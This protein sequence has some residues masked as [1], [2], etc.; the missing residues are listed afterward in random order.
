MA[1]GKEGVSPQFPHCC[2]P[3]VSYTQ[4]ILFTTIIHSVLG[5]YKRYFSF[6]LF[7]QC[8]TMV[9]V[10]YLCTP[11]MQYCDLCK[12]SGGDTTV[13]ERLI[14]S[15]VTITNRNPIRSEDLDLYSVI[16]TQ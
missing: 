6:R 10:C 7:Q 8:N 11:P 5:P 1:F 14:L 2:T 4:Y 13:I 3:P 12:C 9:S 15:L 16:P